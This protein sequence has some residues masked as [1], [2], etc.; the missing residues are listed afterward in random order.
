MRR[1][2]GDITF[3]FALVSRAATFGSCESDS[4]SS[5]E[6]SS[7]VD[8]SEAGFFATGF[9]F[10]VLAAYGEGIG[11]QG[12]WGGCRLPRHLLRLWR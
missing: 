3:I 12:R 5:E 11:E 2:A 4:D 7:E 8:D 1:R 6:E 9:G 10:G